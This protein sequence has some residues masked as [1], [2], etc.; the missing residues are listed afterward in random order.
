MR[1]EAVKR[2]KAEGTKRIGLE[3]QLKIVPV[4]ERR[5]IEGSRRGERGEVGNVLIEEGSE[6]I[7]PF[8]E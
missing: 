6:G 7:P 5:R 3:N 1:T 2:K 4:C 8:R